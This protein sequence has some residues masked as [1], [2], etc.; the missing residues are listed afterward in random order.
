MHADRP[1]DAERPRRAPSE[2]H[3]LGVLAHELRTPITTIYAGSAVLARDEALLPSMRRELAADV[4]AEAA[5]LF[6]AVE[7]LLVLTRLEHGALDLIREPV[8]L[9]RIVESAVR[10]EGPRWPKLD[11]SYRTAGE[12]PP[13]AGDGA[14][15]AHVLRNLVADTGWRAAGGSLEIVVEEAEP[16]SVT[17]RLVDRTGTLRSDDLPTLFDLPTADPRQGLTSRGIAM[18]V[19]ARLIEAMHGRLA[20][21]FITDDVVEIVLTLPADRS[22]SGA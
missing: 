10:L 6:R 8:L 19:A 7:D 3:L 4:Q 11:I 5:R 20:A 16:G 13:I 12:I 17:C 21:T 1:T 22:A 15:L 9:D 14:A 18:Y 2:D